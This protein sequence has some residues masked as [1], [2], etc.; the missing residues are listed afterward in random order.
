[1]RRLHAIPLLLTLLALTVAAAAH[2]ELSQKGNLRI[3]FGGD[4]SPRSLPRDRL[5]PVRFEVDGAIATTDGS[6][7]PPVRRLE[8]ALNRAGRLST[9]GLPA[10]HSAALQ[11]T[12]TAAAL[13]R[14]RPA[15]VGEGHFRANLEFPGV[16]TFPAGGRLLA[17]NGRQHGRRALI[18]HLYVDTPAKVTFILPLLISQKGK[19]QFGTVLSA[20]VPTLAGG[21]GSVTAVDLAIG[22][23]YTFKGRRHSFLSASCAAPPGFPGA[24]FAFARGSFYFSDGRRLD[25]TLNRH[26]DVL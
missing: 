11:S 22:R 9:R 8:I 10:C 12:T 18:L 4:F 3:S 16:G 1:M 24:V 7:P 6:H 15:L 14:C 19:G 23:N 26:C 21:L 2:G 20:K 5:A 13:T 25:T 17:F